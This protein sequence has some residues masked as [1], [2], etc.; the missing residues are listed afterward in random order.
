MSPFAVAEVARLEELRLAVIELRIETDLAEAGHVR[1]IG[2][3]ESLVD[4]PSAA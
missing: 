1:V 3:L 2:E 4:A